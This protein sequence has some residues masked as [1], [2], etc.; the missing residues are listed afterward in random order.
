[1]LS[2]EL[3]NYDKQSVDNYVEVVK[4]EYEQA[5]MEEKLKV[6]ESEKKIFA[7]KKRISEIEDRQKHIL[8]A[9]Q[10]F[11]K[12]QTEGNHNIEILRGEQLRMIY[13]NMQAL[14]Q[15]LNLKYPG[16][17]LNSS[18]KKLINEIDNILSQSA[19]RK[20]EV[21]AGTQNDAM[22]I[23]LSKMQ[24]KRTQEPPREVKIERV[25][26][27]PTQ[28]KPVCDM[29]LGKDDKYDNLVDKFLDTRPEN[30]DKVPFQSTAF[31]LKEAI[32]PTDDLSEI[33]KAFDFYNNN[34]DEDN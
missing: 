8:T 13:L 24:D 33:M 31:D 10:S 15:E 25:V 26:D 32:T 17:L 14:M 21:I 1:M 4:R 11:K 6:L 28:I 7:L 20:D 2:G 27:R 29:K 16:I 23:L 9:L 19:S 12:L 3:N 5:L 30:E 22:R 34:D 18:Y